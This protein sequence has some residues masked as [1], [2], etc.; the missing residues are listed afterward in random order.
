MSAQ[1]I[2]IIDRTVQKTNLWLRDLR[3][4]LHTDDSHIAYQ[5]LRVVLHALRDRLSV[6]EAVALA[7]EL[8]LLIRGI[9]YE[10]WRSAGKPLKLSRDEFLH[11]VQDQLQV[12]G[13]IDPVRYTRAVLSVLGNHLSP[14]EAHKVRA[15]LP[16]DLQALWPEEELVGG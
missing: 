11:R 4:E 2:E 13:I 10:G 5:A 7:A 9:Y 14:G 3:E 12:P 1:S 15:T 8:P 16:K 6:D